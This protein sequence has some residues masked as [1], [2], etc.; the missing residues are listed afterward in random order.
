MTKGDQKLPPNY[1]WNYTAFF[2]DYVFFGVAFNFFSP[3]SVLPRSS[4]S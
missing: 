3:H 1:R 2:L 4:A